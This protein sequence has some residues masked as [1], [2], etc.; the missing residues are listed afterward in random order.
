MFGMK[1]HGGRH[2]MGRDMEG[3][4][5]RG[6][7][8]GRGRRGGRMFDQGGLRVLVLHLIAEKPRHGYE[9][10]RAIEEMTGGNYSPSPGVI[11]PTLTLLEEIGQASVTEEEGGRKLYSITE[12]GKKALEASRQA[13]EVMLARATQSRPAGEQPAG[14]QRAVE[15]LRYALHLRLR[16]ASLDAAQAEALAEL[17]DETARKIEKI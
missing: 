3:P 14:V 11:Y 6:G 2:G 15:N 10:I 4:R 16:G 7:P 17:L 13:L 9:L 8:E 12:E 1:R 5:G